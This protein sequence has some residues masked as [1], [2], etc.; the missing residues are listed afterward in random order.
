MRLDHCPYYSKNIANLCSALAKL[1]RSGFH[2]GDP[3]I[4]TI[5]LAPGQGIFSRNYT[6]DTGSIQ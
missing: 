3:T 6:Y 2:V 1:K 5:I 4:D